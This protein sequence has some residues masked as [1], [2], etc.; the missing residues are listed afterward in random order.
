M[1]QIQNAINLVEIDPEN[2]WFSIQ[3]SDKQF[4]SLLQSRLGCTYLWR[5]RSYKAI[6]KKWSCES[7]DRSML[8][9]SEHGLIDTI[10]MKFVRDLHGISVQFTI[11]IVQE[12]PLVVWKIKVTNEGSEPVEI[13]QIEL[14]RL[15]PKDGGSINF[16]AKRTNSEI[17]F[18]SNGW[19]SWSPTRFY[20]ADERMNISRAGFLQHPMIYNAGTPLPCR[21]GVFSSDMFAVIGDRTARKGFLVGFLSQKNHF[22]SIRADFNR[23]SLQMWANGDSARLD[24]GRS[25]ETDWAVFNPILLD[26]RDPLDKYLEAAARENRVDINDNIPVGWC[27]WYHFYTKVTA[28]DIE[29]NLTAIVEGQERLPLQL[30][31]IDDGFETEVGDWFSFKPTFPEGVAP[32]AKK[33]KQQGL[34]PGLW[35]APFIV[36]PRSRLFHDHPDW[37]LR[38]KS[39]LPVNAGFGWN[40]INTALDL[41][42]PDALAYTCEVIRRAAA[43]WGFAYL[44]LD[45]IYATAL[46]GRYHDPTLTRAQVL[47]HAMESIRQAVGNK[48]TLLGCGAPLGSMLGV[49]DLMRIGPDVSASWHPYFL[50]LRKLIK[51]EPSVPCAQNS[52]RSILT[53]ANLHNH[54][55]VNDPDCLLIRPDSELSLHEVRSL[56][57]A[58]GVTGGTILLSDDLP[59]LPAERQHIAEV[60][61]PVLGERARLVDWFD[62][63]IPARARV[64]LLNETG[65]WQVLAAF[66]WQDQPEDI[67]ITLDD[68][69]LAEGEYFTREF[70]SGE[71]GSLTAEKALIFPKVPA[72]GCVLLSARRVDD[73]KPI[74]VGS[75]LHFSQGVEVAEWKPFDGGVRATLRLPRHTAGEIYFHHPG[76]VKGVEVNGVPGHINVYG[77]KIYSVA[78]EVDGFA[79]IQING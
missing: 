32:L 23:K 10:T 57:T 7:V 43:E 34:T 15:M 53:R 76:E 37:I 12:Y 36:N 52:M 62:S 51:N 40:A 18:F 26:H 13:K 77:N 14:L 72:H 63:F 55:W 59:G 27:S 60:L 78:V 44:K 2:G 49:V 68:F 35:L 61:L 5:G 28:K 16:S 73:D 75:T 42:N 29:D 47:R 38:K 1:H 41:S 25:I 3:P 6:G 67:Q 17:G 74:F 19:Q 79:H 8:D 45:F 30:V 9:T 31:Q 70:W 65:E 22:G 46:R 11:G 20:R 24:A 64:D 66:N 21:K 50:G 56:A 39:G 4:P 54:W 69:K 33:I 48:V 71:L 58:I